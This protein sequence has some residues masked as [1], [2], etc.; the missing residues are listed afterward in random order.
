M[1]AIDT[2]YAAHTMRTT[3]LVLLAACSG[4]APSTT[5]TPPATPIEGSASTPPSAPAI[6]ADAKPDKGTIDPALAAKVTGIL[7]AFIEYNPDF[8]PDGKRVVFMSN[9]DGL[10]QL[11][12]GD[13]AKPAAPPA[14]IV[15]TTER[16]G[17]Y[18]LLKD[19]RTILFISDVGADENWSIFRV[20]IDG[21]GLID[22]TPGERINRD[23]PVVP[24]KKQD[25]MYFTARTMS[26]AKSTLYAA[27]TRTPGPA[28]AIYTDDLPMFLSA[29]SPDGGKALV[30]QVPSGDENYALLIDIATGKAERIF[31]ATGKAALS[32]LEFSPDGKTIYI[33][34]DNGTEQ[35]TLLAIDART[36]KILAKHDFAPTG[37]NAGV[38][39]VSR[40]TGAI[41]MTV[42][43]GS[44]AEIRILDGKTLVQRSALKMPLGAGAAVDWSDDGKRLAVHWSTPSTPTTLFTVDGASGMSTPIRTE[45]RPTLKD[46]PAIDASV[47]D[48]PAFDGGRIPTNIYVARGESTTPHPTIVYF[49]GGPSS[50]SMIKWQVLT[51]FFVSLGYAVVEP[52]VRGSGGYGRAF[53]AADNGPKRLDAFKDIETT[54]RWIARQPWADKDRLVAMGSSYG[55]YST[56]IALARSPAIWR[57]GVDL[58][59]IVNLETFMKTTA[60]VI[61]TLFLVEFGDPDK[62]AAFLRQISPITDVDEIVDPTFIYAGANDP[63]VPRTESDLIVKAL[64]TRK[65]P[66]EYM[67]AENEGHS[68]ARRE[69]Q[70]ELYARV[71]RFLE[72][73]LR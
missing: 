30:S 27:S 16:I 8:T 21:K 10:P 42:T 7:E 25:T 49:H 12:L 67:V 11:Y 40:K 24:D 56:L 13:P 53:E 17:G 32:A 58:V 33:G 45:P 69:N 62:D 18:Q 2:L 14:R 70:I 61:R 28:K 20:G 31:P 39:L 4:S 71:A 22:L 19:G 52:N 66:S 15:T 38:T 60:G 23:G 72:A 43:V 1:H 63:R 73:A 65:V 5:T 64:R 9:R 46:M 29:M 48:I 50:V 44:Y 51:A 55:G 37:A 36:K 54:G 47:V 57:A 59:G 3:L 68:L 34:T 26:E 41:A 35:S 6:A